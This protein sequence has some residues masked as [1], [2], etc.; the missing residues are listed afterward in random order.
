MAQEDRITE[1]HK[2]YFEPYG[3]QPIL[4][5]SKGYRNLK[6]TEQVYQRKGKATP[7]WTPL[8]TGWLSGKPLGLLLLQNEEGKFRETIPTP[9]ELLASSRKSIFIAFGDESGNP[10]SDAVGAWEV[11]PGNSFH[12]IPSDASRVF[13]RCRSGVSVARFSLVLIPG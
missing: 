3:E 9:E 4:F 5:E 7:I 2:V 11:L 1:L 10:P 13:L 6:T 12:G 8:D